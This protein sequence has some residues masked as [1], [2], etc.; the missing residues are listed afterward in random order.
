M[1]DDHMNNGQLKA[2]YNIQISTN[3]QLIANYDIYP[4]PTDTLTLPTHLESF[5]NLYNTKPEEVTADS[6]YGSEQNYEYLESNG[7]NHFVKYNYFHQEQQGI[8][9][10]K[11]PFLQDYL[12]YNKSLDT[13]FC[14]MGQ[15]MT[16]IGT[17]KVINQS[18]FTQEITRYQAENCNGCPM[19]GVCHK[20]QENRIIE[21]NHNLIRH[22]K[23]AK[24][25]LT[26]DE[27]IY[28][29]KKRPIEVESVFGNIK[30]NKSFRRFML[31]GK[32][33]VAIEFGL[34]AIAH[35]LSKK[36]V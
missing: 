24:E 5:N 8:R 19:R 18:G 27:G 22:K 16:N 34:I 25:N 12:Y 20:S 21:V 23:K 26:S 6:G 2:G 11:H 4:N 36:V 3:N 7:I 32:K 30:Q 14:P 31:R 28:H 10:R 1:K 15:K 33:K 17:K 9:Q 35:N 29:R 13:Y